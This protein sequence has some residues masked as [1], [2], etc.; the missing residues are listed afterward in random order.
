MVNPDS[1]L[2][3]AHPEWALVT[4][5]YEPV[6]GRNQ[7]VLD[8][9]RPEAFAARPRV[10]RRAA[11][12]SRHLLRE[13]G[14]EPRPRAGVGLRRRRR[15]ARQTLA[16]YCAAR[17]VAGAASDGRVRVVCERRR[18]HRPRDPATNRAGVDERLQRCARTSDHPA[19]R[20]DADPARGDGCAHRPDPRAHHGPGALARVPGGDGAVRPPRGGVGR[21]DARRARARRARRGDCICTS[22]SDR[23]CTAATPCASTPSRRTALTVSYA[24]DRSEGAGVVRPA[25]HGA[26]P[27]AAGAP[28][29]RGSIPIARTGPSTSRCHVSGGGS[30]PVNRRGSRTAWSCRAANWPF[31]DC[32][33][34]YC[35][36]SRPCCSTSEPS[37]TSSLPSPEK[38]AGCAPGGHVSAHFGLGDAP[39][40][41]V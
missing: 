19:R 31:M 26:E 18:S 23:S 2:L 29:C 21:H 9:A 5:G 25:G 13:V 7:L 39:I 20:L 22:G 11:S 16:L 40:R 24:P 10:A 32:G 4:D 30:P 34:R 15:H 1:D 14:H 35:T 27:H 8:L 33:P 38:C 6:L 37:V 41:G 3:R 36:P 28:H 12:R 17:R